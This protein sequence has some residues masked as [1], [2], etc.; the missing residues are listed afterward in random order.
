MARKGKKKGRRKSPY[1]DYNISGIDQHKREGSRLK[2]PL[3]QLNM[4]PSSWADDHMPE[5][6]WAVLLAGVLDRSHYL[7]LFRQVAVTCREWPPSEGEAPTDPGFFVDMTRLGEVDDDKF[8]AFAAVLLAHPL[9][10]AS[11]RPLLL[12]EA[13]P[14][15]ERWKAVLAVEPT[16]DDWQTLARAVAMV[17][18]HQSEQS[19]DIRWFKLI[20]TIIAGRLFYPEGSEEHL[21]ELRLFPDRGDM[22]SVR[23]RIRSAEMMIRRRN[24]AAWVSEFWAQALR[25]TRCMDPSGD[26][27]YVFTEPR[28]DPESLWEVRRRLISS[29]HSNLQPKRVDAKLDGAFGIV[30]YALSLIEELC[31]HCVQTR[32]TGRL[33][34]RTLVEICITLRYLRRKGRDELWQ[35]YRVYGAGQAKLAFLKAQELQGDLP[36]FLDENALYEIANEDTW[37]EYLDIDVGHWATTNLRRLAMESESKDLY[38]KY[39]DWTS[40]VT[41]GHWGAVRDTNLVTCHNPLHRLHRIPRQEHRQLASVESDAIEI[42]NIML[43]EI[44]SLYPGSESLGMI[45]LNE[46]SIGS[47]V[48]SHDRTAG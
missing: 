25:Q 20:V 3:A 18:D 37:Q 5:M 22:R 36:P 32:I 15:L 34:L 10:Y 28:I 39:Y 42:A 40:T 6:L 30:L 45:M 35:S 48:G 33:V 8:R 21:E 41:H 44:E 9:G 13:L 38:D 7:Q 4:T 46:S 2:P 27:G 14:G 16:N 26:S 19:T 24:L 17:L 43:A 29:F 1:A 31:M 47:I 12:I 11:L 23:P